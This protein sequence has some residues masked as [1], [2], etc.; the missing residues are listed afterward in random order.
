VR[1]GAEIVIAGGGDAESDLD[2]V[3][4]F[5]VQSGEWRISG[6]METVLKTGFLIHWHKG[7]VQSTWAMIRMI[8]TCMVYK[9][10]STGCS[11]FS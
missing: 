4:I 10:T 1:G 6:I 2:V 11:I 9:M 5:N 7:V 3:E 8:S